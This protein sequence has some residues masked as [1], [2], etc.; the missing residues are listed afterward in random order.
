MF[1]KLV[2]TGEIEVD[3]RTYVVHY[4]ELRTARGAR[5]Y[6]CEILLEAAR[7][8]HR[9]RRLADQPRAEGGP[10]GAGDALQPRA[11]RPSAVVAA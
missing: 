6:S 10:A 4:F 8:H 7:S 2:K 1:R 11:G 3:G 9:R 5:R